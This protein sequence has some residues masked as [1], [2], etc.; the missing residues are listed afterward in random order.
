M[1]VYVVKRLLAGAVVMV[2]VSMSIFLLAL[3]GG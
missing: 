2:L 1:F 3:G